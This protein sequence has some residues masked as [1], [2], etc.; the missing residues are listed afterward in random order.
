M[1]IQFQAV[2]VKEL[3]ESVR[4]FWKQALVFFGYALFFQ[5]SAV[6]KWASLAETSFVPGNATFKQNLQ[7]ATISPDCTLALTVPVVIPL[8]AQVILNKSMLRDRV[9]GTLATVLATGT[10]ESLLWSADVVAAFL[11]GL[12]PAMLS[13]VAGDLLICGHLGPTVALSARLA[14]WGLFVAPLAA[15]TIVVLTAF[16]YWAT[17]WPDMIV[18]CFPVLISLGLFGYCVDHPVPQVSAGTIAVSSLVMLLAIG[19]CLFLTTRLSRQFVVG[20]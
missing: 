7:P 17:R 8:F 9:G 18:S 3:R 5:W 10:S 13:M 19:I 15:L 14:L 4:L 11:C 1:L 2:L 16:L 6:G 20:L 12:P